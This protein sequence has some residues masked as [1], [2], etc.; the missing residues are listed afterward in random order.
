MLS[1]SIVQKLLGSIFLRLLTSTTFKRLITLV[2]MFRRHA[3]GNN[4]P[5]TNAKNLCLADKD[6]SEFNKY[7]VNSTKSSN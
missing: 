7:D 6:I 1:S 3:P 4:E 5:G 2:E